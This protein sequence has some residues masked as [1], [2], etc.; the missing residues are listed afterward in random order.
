MAHIILRFL[1]CL[2]VHNF[3]AGETDEVFQKSDLNFMAKVTLGNK[4]ILI[5]GNANE[6]FSR[7]FEA[8]QQ[9]GI[10]SERFKISSALTQLKI[11]VSIFIPSVH[12]FKKLDIYLRQ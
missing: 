2:K 8:I 11:F 6:K 7:P 10:G 5:P 4:V 3:N 9:M 1:S 12:Y